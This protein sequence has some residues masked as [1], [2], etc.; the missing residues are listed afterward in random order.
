MGLNFVGDKTFKGQDFTK[1]R[2]PKA[3]Y[4]NCIFEGC[5]FSNSYLDNQNFLECEFIDCNL[6]NANITHTTFNEVLFS[7]CKMIGLKFETL[8][9]FLIAFRF[10]DCTMN[11]CSFY[12]MELKNQQFDHCKLIETD[13]IETD[14]TASV[15]DACDLQNARFEDSNLEKVDFRTSLNIGFNPNKNHIKKA[16]F[17][18]ENVLGLLNDFDIIIE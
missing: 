11:L 7:S 1:N 4:E 6:S 15:F 8:N 14:L 12:Q 3:E 13:F 10:K 16:K 9:D 18:K 2:L 5:D 17:S